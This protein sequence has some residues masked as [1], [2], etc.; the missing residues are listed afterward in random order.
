MTIRRLS[1]SDRLIGATQAGANVLT[2]KTISA[3]PNPAD[4][5][6]SAPNDP[7]Q[8]RLP[9]DAPSARANYETAALMRVNHVGEICAQ[10]LY[11]GQALTARN[12]A[13]RAAFEESAREEQDHLVWTAQRLTELNARP[14]LF[15]PVWYAGSFAIGAIA[16]LGGDRK[17]LGFMAETERQVELHLEGHLQRLPAADWRSR[18]IVAQMKR[19]ES[20]HG[21]KALE[22]GGQVPTWPIPA[23]M[24]SVAKLMTTVSY[25]L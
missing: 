1:W 9:T 20:A 15:N 12:E 10:A 19:D 23:L 16:G 7:A 5:A 11:S 14:S 18:A 25:R 3:R 2:G 8:D 17:S 21:A 22:L 13:I 24:R 4:A 6:A